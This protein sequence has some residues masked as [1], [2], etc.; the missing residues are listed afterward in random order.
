MAP[1]LL[2]MGIATVES[3]TFSLGVI[4]CVVLRTYVSSFPDD[5]ELLHLARAMVCPDPHWRPRF[6]LCL[7]VL[8]G[9]LDAPRR[10]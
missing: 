8:A 5:F 6:R 7:D 3:D 1:E 10:E 9:N 2:Q 4:L